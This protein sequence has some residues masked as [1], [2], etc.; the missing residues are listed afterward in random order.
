MALTLRERQQPL[1]D[2]Y[3]QDPAAATL[4]HSVRTTPALDDPLR[5]RITSGAASWE[6]A[7]HRMAGGP[8][9]EA[10]SGD[11]LLAA[12]AGCQ[13]ITLKMVAASMGLPLRDLQVTVTGEMDFRGTMGTDRAVPI[14]YQRIVCEIHVRA[15]GDPGRV[16]RL[17]EK[18]EQ[19]CVVRATLT[20]G[21]PVESHIIVDEA[22]AA[23]DAADE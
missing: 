19:Y 11:V 8:D 17:I 21:V 22:V 15:D 12:L 6:I 5:S 20:G 16:A 13:E 3:R 23:A 2:R 14:G 7:A 10:C 1:K 9:E 4:V 18:A